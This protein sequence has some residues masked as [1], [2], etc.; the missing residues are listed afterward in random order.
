[1][2]QLLLIASTPCVLIRAVVNCTGLGVKSTTGHLEW[3]DQKGLCFHD[4]CAMPG[5]RFLRS[6]EM[7]EQGF[8][9]LSVQ[10]SYR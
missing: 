8:H 4:Y 7:L 6:G 5:A 9:S 3:L 2:E 10:Y 1:M